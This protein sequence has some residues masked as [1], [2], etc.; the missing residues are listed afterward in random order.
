MSEQD[1]LNWVEKQH[2]AE[3]HLNDSKAEMWHDICGSLADAARSFNKL[4]G[5]K[6]ESIPKNGHRFRIVLHEQDRKRLID[7]DFDDQ[8][9]TITSEYDASPQGSRI[10]HLTADHTLAFFIDKS[11]NRLTADQVSQAILTPSFFPG[12]PSVYANRG[13]LIVG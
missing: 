4:Y 2:R 7:V 5:G 12:P 11:G 6:T 13:P 10:F 9:C 8:S 3:K 1:Q